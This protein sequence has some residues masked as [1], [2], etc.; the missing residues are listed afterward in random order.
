MPLVWDCS[1]CHLSVPRGWVAAAGPLR[2]SLPIL[3]CQPGFPPISWEW[4]SLCFG[5][6]TLWG[7][8]CRV[9]EQVSPSKA[10][11]SLDAPSCHRHCARATGALG[12]APGLGVQRGPEPAHA[13]SGELGLISRPRLNKMLHH[14][15]GLRRVSHPLSHAVP[16]PGGGPERGHCSWMCPRGSAQT[17]VH[18]CHINLLPRVLP[19]L[20]S[21]LT[22][23]CSPS[24]PLWIFLFSSDFINKKSEP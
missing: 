6:S 10:H 14:W 1:R 2:L 11:V 23:P 16:M 15:L 4:L 18:C 17:S 19:E 20:T 8:T 12:A 13:A 24:F 22:A 7:M 3:C 5:N 21:M 9:F